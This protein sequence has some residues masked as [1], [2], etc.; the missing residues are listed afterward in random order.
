MYATDPTASR[1]ISALS[2]RVKFLEAAATV[3]A[4]NGIWRCSRTG[5]HVIER[6]TISNHEITVNLEARTIQVARETL[7]FSRDRGLSPGGVAGMTGLLSDSPTKIEWRDG[8][9]WTR[10][11]GREG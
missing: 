11:P 5:L 4:L 1:T 3:A 10:V 6:G 8:R 9:V 7:A 2:D